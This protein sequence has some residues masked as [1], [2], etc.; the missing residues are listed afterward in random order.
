MAIL[1]G[2]NNTLAYTDC[3]PKK[4]GKLETCSFMWNY[5]KDNGYVTAYGEDEASIN[6]FNYN[7]FGFIKPPTDY[8]MRPYCL[9]AEKSLHAK[10]K[11]SL[12]FCL[13]YKHYADHIYDYAIDFATVYKN[14]PSFGLFWTNTF[15]HNAIS[16]PSSMDM[17]MK[18]YIEELEERGILNN[19][20]VV[21]FSDHGL[22]FGPIRVLE[23]G[24]FEERLPFI[25]IWLPEWFKKENPEIVQ[26]LKI[27]RN[28]LTNPYDLHMTLKHILELSGRVEKLPLAISCPECHSIFKEVS[29]DRS[30]ED[31]SITDHW[32]TCAA[33][34]K[35]DRKSPII[36]KAVKFV[37]E[38]INS[39]LEQHRNG[40]KN[41]CAKLKLSLI[42]Y[43]REANVRNISEPFDNYLI[44]F[45][46]SP[47]GG[48]FESTVKYYLNDKNFV[49]SGSVSRLN[50][51]D[52][53]SHCMHIDYL[54]K[55]C[56]C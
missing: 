24:W 15:S 4:V 21:F 51:Y 6:T 25:F 7:K 34:E 49:L 16:D 22:R 5:F 28:R 9:A 31:V 39:D 55:Y 56:Y 54:K 42:E 38:N 12:K 20:M 3:D 43:A 11:S 27:N 47:G 35:A 37:L 48:I 41:L 17:K 18:R 29:V 40:T 33:Y 23:T 13:G 46:A 36:N 1:V 53:Q 14:D 50:S 26:A 10:Y 19:S 52:S 45:K 32:C 30:C 8:Y 44:V 2:V